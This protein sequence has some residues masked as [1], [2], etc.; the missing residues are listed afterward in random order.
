MQY[1]EAR[2]GRVFVIRLEDGEIV[3]HQIEQFAK[4]HAIERALLIVIGSA[5]KGSLL[6][7]GPENSRSQP[8]NPMTQEQFFQTTKETP[9]ST[10]TWLAAERKIQ[11]PGAFAQG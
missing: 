7:V 4:D 1:S 10:C 6:V 8:I 9:Y 3:H 2:Q 11:S 5:D